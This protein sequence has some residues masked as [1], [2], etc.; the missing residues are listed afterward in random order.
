MRP[1]AK[2]IAKPV[3]EVKEMAAEESSCS[4]SVEE[5][6]AELD[7]ALWARELLEVLLASSEVLASSSSSLALL[8]RVVRARVELVASEESLASSSS[9]ELLAVASAETS[10]VLA[11]MAL[12][13]ALPGLLAPSR[14]LT[15]EVAEAWFARAPEPQPMVCPSGWMDSGAALVDCRRRAERTVSRWP[16]SVRP[17][18]Q[19]ALTPLVEAMGKRVVQTAVETSPPIVNWNW[20]NNKSDNVRT[21]SL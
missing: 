21:L 2:T 11:V 7:E 13:V 9:A 5:V 3:A 12:E 1:P 16:L 19:T 4:S 17:E 18:A 10:L 8:L 14:R 20:N 6:L 15:M